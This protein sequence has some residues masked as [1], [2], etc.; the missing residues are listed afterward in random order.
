[1]T[2]LLILWQSCTIWVPLLKLAHSQMV[3]RGW[4]VILGD[5]AHQVLRDASMLTDAVVI[6]V[7]VR[8]SIT[9]GY[10]RP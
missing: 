10:D 3:Y 8:G 2:Q 1:M 7:T 9:A 6:R 4:G 5:V